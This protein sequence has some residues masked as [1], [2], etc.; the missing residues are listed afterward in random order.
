MLSLTTGENIIINE[1]VNILFETSNIYDITPATISRVG[2]IAVEKELIN[3]FTIFKQW[4]E[5]SIPNS[6]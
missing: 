6:I 5:S 2:V 4:W 3:E 1:N